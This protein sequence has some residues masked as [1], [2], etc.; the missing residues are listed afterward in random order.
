MP[1]IIVLAFQRRKAE[2]YAWKTACHLSL[3]RNDCKQISYRHWSHIEQIKNHVLIDRCVLFPGCHALSPFGMLSRSI[4]AL[5]EHPRGSVQGLRKTG[6][7]GSPAFQWAGWSGAHEAFDSSIPSCPLR[8]NCLS[9]FFFFSL[10]SKVVRSFRLEEICT[11]DPSNLFFPSKEILM[12][13]T[14]G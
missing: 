8:S 14:L 6:E 5:P 1:Q 9:R 4:P 2:V 11:S 7:P 13:L 12:W 10:L 3:I